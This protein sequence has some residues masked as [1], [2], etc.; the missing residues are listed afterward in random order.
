MSITKLLA[1]VLDS[2]V[3]PTQPALI[4]GK[5]MNDNIH[6]VQEL[7]KQYIR[8]CI[9]PRCMLKID[10]RKA[11]DSIRWEFLR[12]VLINVGFPTKLFIR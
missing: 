4:E 12:E 5:S 1:K 3:D 10:L 7:F 11:Y 2:I 6:L 9:S 8:K